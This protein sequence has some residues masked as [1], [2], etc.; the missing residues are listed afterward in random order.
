MAN[1]L[2]MAEVQTILGLLEKGWSHRRIAR[3]LG[4]N[5][6]TVGR[7]A[8]LRPGP[9]SPPKADPP[10]AGNPAN[11]PPGCETS[12]HSKPAN[13]T[14]GSLS[15]PAS[16][17]EPFREFILRK[18]NEGLSGV[19]IWQDLVTDH[20]F[21][22]SYS[23]LKR[24]LRRLN[25]NQELPFRRI[26]TPPGEEAQV[27]FGTGAW[28][29]KDGK[30]RK[31]YVFRITLSYSRKSYSEAVW[32]QTTDNFIRCL[33]NAFRWFGGVPKTLVLDNL[34]AAVIRADWFDP[35][36][37][38]KIQDFAKHYGIVIL[39]TKP[40]TPRHKGKIE[41]GIKYVKNNALAGKCFQDLPEQN[42]YLRH[43]ET[44]IADT[45]IH[46]TTRQQ[47]KKLFE[48]EKTLLQP[49]ALES[50]PNYQEGE[51]T[52][53][54]DGHVEVAKAYYSVPPEYLG[55]KLWVRWDSRF[56]RIYNQ[57]FEQVAIHSRVQPGRFHTLREHLDDRKISAVERG[58]E[59]LIRK[60]FHIGPS[61]GQWAKAMID[62]RGIEGVR[63][64]QGLLNLTTRYPVEVLNQATGHALNAQCF[65]LRPLRELCQRFH[66][67]PA[68]EFSQNHSLIRPLSEYQ[69]LIRVSF[70]TASTQKEDSENE[71]LSNP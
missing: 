49:L 35:E 12:N 32:Q 60:A 6:E 39:P 51:R 18:F 5:R 1:Q 54:R 8:R 41:S 4:V 15:G 36:L 37:S 19:R 43:W 66:K 27:D 25:R 42:A 48:I 52:V 44:H 61:V 69:N 29:F 11:P 38:P 53:H 23:A 2:K 56:V 21:S 13:P 67:Q 33:E 55:R 47:V 62:A 45:R 24:F 22:K 20:N 57:R 58:A 63:V 34:K 40:Y 9:D 17:C 50:F 30:K 16:S 7:Y 46:G 59:F 64:L 28:T 3:E 10:L 31:P 65:R 71:V 26:E 70:Q 68:L 14:L